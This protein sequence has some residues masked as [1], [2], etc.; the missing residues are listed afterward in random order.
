MTQDRP[1]KA[2]GSTVP[3]QGRVSGS[4]RPGDTT[5]SYVLGEFYWRVQMGERVE[6]LDYISPPYS[7]SAEG[8]KDE[9][10][11]STGVY[12]EPFEIAS[13]FGDP[14]RLHADA[15]RYRRRAALPLTWTLNPLWTGSV[16]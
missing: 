10:T 9:I 1:A 2:G 16:S 5:V 15:D 8:E 11:W 4:S 13:A 7:L 14:V 6:Y 3:Y 12:V